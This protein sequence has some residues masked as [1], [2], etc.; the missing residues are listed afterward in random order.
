MPPNADPHAERVQDGERPVAFSDDGKALWL[1]RRGEVPGS[2]YRV[3][4][5]TGRRD[6]TIPLHPP[7]TAGIYSIV[8][9]AITPD[10]Q[11]YAYSY[12]R[13]L[14]ELYPATGLR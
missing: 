1:F 13:V 8:E 10:G 4:I 12:T 6:R 3:D 2:V 14:S 9:C 11:A 7:D 5:A